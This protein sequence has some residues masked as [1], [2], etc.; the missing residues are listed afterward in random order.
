MLENLTIINELPGY[1]VIFTRKKANFPKPIPY[2]KLII[3]SQKAVYFEIPKVAC[4][5]INFLLIRLFIRAGKKFSVQEVHTDPD[6]PR[7]WGRL[8]NKVASYFKF[9]FVRDPLTRIQSC[10]LDKIKPIGFN[11]T[12]AYENGL[13]IPFKQFG[14]LFWPGM[15]FNDFAVSV[16]Q[17]D[18][19]EADPHFRSQSSFVANNDDELEIDFIGKFENL[20]SDLTRLLARFGVEPDSIQIP[21]VNK[22][23]RPE[24]WELTE[25]TRKLIHDRYHR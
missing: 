14:D 11:E 17:I 9:A 22:Q 19:Q 12:E 4:T 2:K 8:D 24:S 7:V 16:S 25:R 23:K 13:Y 10:F 5:T 18:D 3:D 6:L 21:I 15:N 1:R 20:E